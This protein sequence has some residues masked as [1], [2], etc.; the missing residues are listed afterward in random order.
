MFK[1]SLSATNEPIP[2]SAA[3]LAPFVRS[4]V[5]VNVDYDRDDAACVLTRTSDGTQTEGAENVVRTLAKE[6]GAESNSTQV[7]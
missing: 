1:L 6:A 4:V 5:Q 7:C 2:Y 3:V